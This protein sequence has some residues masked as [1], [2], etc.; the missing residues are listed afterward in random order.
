MTAGRDDCEVCPRVALVGA[1]VSIRNDTRNDGSRPPRV[2]RKQRPHSAST[3]VGNRVGLEKNSGV[4]VG[5]GDG[6]KER[7]RAARYETCSGTAAAERRVQTSAGG[8]E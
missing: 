8:H 1:D 7:S 5:N 3:I 4:G 6:S 2:R